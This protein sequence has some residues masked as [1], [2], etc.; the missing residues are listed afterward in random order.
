MD[1]N[2]FHI[3]REIGAESVDESDVKFH[4]TVLELTSSA[5]REYVEELSTMPLLEGL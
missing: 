4:E 2:Q 1:T 3:A 5:R